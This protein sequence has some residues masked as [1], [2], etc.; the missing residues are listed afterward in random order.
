MDLLP[1]ELYPSILL[2][3]DLYD[4]LNV[5]RV[6]PK[7][8]DIV[9]DFK[10][11]ELVWPESH[12]WCNARR[13]KGN[14]FH[15]GQPYEFSYTMGEDLQWLLNKS[16]LNFQFL[17]RARV[18]WLN[19]LNDF[20]HLEHVEIFKI[21]CR[22]QD[23][24][25]LILPKLKAFEIVLSSAETRNEFSLELETPKLRDV[26][27]K[28][29]CPEKIKFNHPLAVSYLKT[30]RSADVYLNETIAVFKN[31]QV[32]EYFGHTAI[33][34]DFLEKFAKLNVLKIDGRISNLTDFI[35]KRK[36]LNAN[37]RIYYLGVEQVVGNELRGEREFNLQEIANRNPL[38]NP[39]SRMRFYLKYYPRLDDDLSEC[40]RLEYEDLVVRGLTVDS[41]FLR[42]FKNIQ[43]IQISQPVEKP[44]QLIQLI[45]GSPNLFELKLTR[46]GLNQ[47]FYNCLPAIS[48]LFILQIYRDPP[49]LRLNFNFLA[50]M[51]QLEE[52]WTDHNI[53]LNEHQAPDLFRYLNWFVFV[54]N[55]NNFTLRKSDVKGRYVLQVNGDKLFEQSTSNEVVRWSAH[56][57]KVSEQS[58]RKCK[59]RKTSFKKSKK[60][61]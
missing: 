41:V 5:R 55:D 38:F 57:C 7:F 34:A 1:V 49:D 52:L 15:T 28:G 40:F 61:E 11:K 21:R 14:W 46:S 59:T 29:D 26:S 30:N 13:T 6:C 16:I 44:D 12:H 24:Y 53:I 36:E 37:F 35:L 17:K 48:S 23:S 47:T 33:E 51:K 10:I 60:K 18:D 56:V 9:Q 45:G 43:S 32:F 3:L 39:V 27:I 2:Y 54:F 8:R 19:Q 50:R 20:Q 42:K 58:K 4:L 25:K 22:L 31:L